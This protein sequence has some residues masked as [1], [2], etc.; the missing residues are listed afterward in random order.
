MSVKKISNE[1]NKQQKENITDCAHLNHLLN[2]LEIGI[3]YLSPQGT[4]LSVNNTAENIFGIDSKELFGKKINDSRWSII[5]ENGVKATNEQHPFSLVMEHREEISN[6]IFGILNSKK[7]EYIWIKSTAIPD[8]HPGEKAPYRII[9]TMQEVS[10]EKEVQASSKEKYL[11]GNVESR[12]EQ[13][14]SKKSEEIMLALIESINESIA[15]IKPDGTG[16]LA[17]STALERLKIQRKDFLSANIFDLFPT[18]IVEARK[19]KIAKVTA[20]KNPLQFEDCQDGRHMQNSLL[21]ILDKKGEVSQIAIFSVDITKNKEVENQIQKLSKVVEQTADMVLITD[22]DGKIEYVNPAFEKSVGYSLP[23]AIGKNPRILKSG[24]QGHEFYKELWDTILAGKTFEAEIINKKKNGELYTEI[25]TITPMKNERGEITNFVA[26]AK[27]ITEK[28]SVQ[29]EV[30]M[31][32]TISDFANYGKAISDLDGKLVYINPY[33][34]HIHGYEPQELLGKELKIFHNRDQSKA[35]EETIEQ[36]NESGQFGPAELWHVR[37]DGSQFLMLHHGVLIYDEEGKPKYLSTSAIDITEAKQTNSRLQK[38]EHRNRSIVEA[39]PDILFRINRDYIFLDFHTPSENHLF[40]PSEDFLGKTI[41]EVMPTEISQPTIEQIELAFTTGNLQK[42]E[43]CLGDGRNQKCF[44]ARIVASVNKDEAIIIIRDITENKLANLLTDTIFEIAEATQT[45]DTLPELYKQ[46]HI[47]IQAIMDARNFYIALYDEKQ[48]L[49]RFVYSEDEMDIRDSTPF[50]PKDSLTLHVLQTGKPL[51]YDDTKH[52]GKYHYRKRRC[53]VWIGVPLLKHGKTIGVIAVQHY[54]D[55][56]AYS[57]REL[58]MLEFVS[59]QVAI[60]IDRKQTEE[61]ARRIEKRNSALI[62]NAPDGITLLDSQGRFTFGSPSAYRAFEYSPETMIGKQAIDYVHPEDADSLHEKFVRLTEYPGESFTAEYRFLHQDGTYRWISGTFHNLLKDPDVQ[63][64]VNNFKDFTERKLA[65]IQLKHNQEI[66]E[67]SQRVAHLGSWDF[68]PETGSGQWSKEMF[69]LFECDPTNGVPILEDFLELLQ[70]EDRQSVLA[71]HQFVSQTG[72]SATLVYSPLISENKPHSRR[73]YQAT[74]NP[75]FDSN[76]NVNRVFGTV[77]DITVI[78]KVQLELEALNRDLEKRVEKRTRIIRDQEAIYRALFENSNDGIYLINPE[79]YVQKANQRAMNM[80][81]YTFEEYHELEAKKVN[82]NTPSDQ[83]QDAYDKLAEV[84]N[85]NQIPLYER[86]FIA[87]DGHQFPVEINLSPVYNDQGEIV[88]AQSVVRDITERKKAE[89]ELL[90]SRN[91]LH[92]ANLELEKASR[93]KDDF[94]ASMSH[95]LRTPL[96]GILGLSEALQLQTFGNLNAKQL[97]AIENIESSGRH[98]LDLINDILDLSKIAAGKLDINFE[99]CEVSK[100][101]QESLSLTRGM[102]EKK[103][104]NVEFT[105]HPATIKL[106]TDSRRLKQMLVNLLSNAIKFTPTMRNLGLEVNLDKSQQ[107]IRF[108]VWD[109]GKGIKPEDMEKLFKP[110]TQIDSELNRMQSGTG[111]GLSL[112]QRMTKLLGGKV[113]VE[114]SFGKGS[115]FTI[116]LPYSEL[117]ISEVENKLEVEKAIE[118]HQTEQIVF[119]TDDK[120]DQPLVMIAD[121]NEV[122]RELFSNFLQA[123][124]FRVET[125][126]RSIDL[127]K[128]IPKHIPNIILMDIQMPIMDDLNTIRTI[129]AHPNT[130]IAKTP[131]IAITALEL[132]GDRERCLEAGADQYMSKPIKLTN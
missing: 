24:E 113:E 4:I 99:P 94:L 6:I 115:R 106:L 26:T 84:L 79:G 97:N 93:L 81:G 37:K 71:T 83:E 39:I 89:D 96:T 28:K 16:I 43:Y 29:E 13:Q 72:Q 86:T 67:M 8:F 112:V 59:N 120:I 52:F 49:L 54:S 123:N 27:D 111:L 103:K 58:H 64:I 107:F 15:I 90:E 95:E 66:L 130:I 69:E 61:R 14:A 68:D 126:S 127:L 17:N 55:P 91:K 47:Q 12:I 110:F 116:I 117:D 118:V 5:F 60:A 3:L 25:K 129:R 73:Y 33:F 65:F 11:G 80:L 124:G 22:I 62:Q 131:L 132:K 92:A 88:M 44:E 40:L 128:K 82:F 19:R 20:N 34:A 119:P 122:I 10:R 101:C 100:I 21:P 125:F 76:G 50:H 18:E 85:G 31:F 32:K 23:E 46:I 36:L 108:S 77:L 1:V 70:P 74:Y 35:V 45:A 56:N 102:L 42:F 9:I 104:Q 75:S 2:T 53:A 114:S 48:D 63:A 7:K 105:M 78:K 41:P 109:Q 30:V 51:F 98:L 57:E 121:N 87:K 38:S